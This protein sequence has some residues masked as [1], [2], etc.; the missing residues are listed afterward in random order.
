MADENLVAWHS[1]SVAEILEALH[2]H[3]AQGLTSAEAAARLQ[4][5][6]SSC[7]ILLAVVYLPF[8]RPVFDFYP[9]GLQGGG[10]L[11]PL[12]LIPVVTA[13]TVKFFLRRASQ[14]RLNSLGL[15]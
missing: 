14:R 8:S 4:R 15:A 11:V 1:R 12:L 7:L 10:L 5:V 9:L 2:P 13:E 3:R 6:A